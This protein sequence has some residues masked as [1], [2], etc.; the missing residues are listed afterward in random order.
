M[1][2]SLACPELRSCHSI[3]TISKNL[4]KLKNQQFLDVRSKIIGQTIE[5]KMETDEWIQNIT[6]YQSRSPGT[7]TPLG[8]LLGR[9][10]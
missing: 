4:K 5:Q 9:K 7:N 3:V 6:I 10:A 2:S 1:G 8:P